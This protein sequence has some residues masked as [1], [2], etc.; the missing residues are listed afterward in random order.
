MPTWR[1]STRC[2]RARAGFQPVNDLV[3]AAPARSLLQDA[4]PLWPACR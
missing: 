4:A 1:G 3:A 2:E